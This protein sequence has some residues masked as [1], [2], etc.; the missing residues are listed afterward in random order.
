MLLEELKNCLGLL[1]RGQ[2][3]IF[4]KPLRI[5]EEGWSLASTYEYDQQDKVPSLGESEIQAL[6][7]GELNRLLCSEEC[8]QKLKSILK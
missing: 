1:E 7:R 4:I 5:F 2:K 6:V 3:P 8:V